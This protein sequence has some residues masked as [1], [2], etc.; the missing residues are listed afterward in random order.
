[1]INPH[2]KRERKAAMLLLISMLIIT[3][4]SRITPLSWQYGETGPEMVVLNPNTGDT[5]FVFNTSTTSVG[6]RFNATVWIYNVTDMFGYQTL[7]S[8]NDTLLNIT[9]A[10]LPTW[11]TNWVFYGQSS[12]QPIPAFRD[13]NGNGVFE[14]VLVGASLLIGTPFNGTGLLSIIE[15]EIIFEPTSGSVSCNLDIDNI[16]SYALDFD[17]T[18]I[19]LIKTGGYYEFIFVPGVPV[20]PTAD[21]TY[22]PL[23][24]LVNE[25]ITFD[26]ST[27]TPNGGSIAN[28]TWNFDDGTPQVAETDPITTHTYLS[29]GT[30]NVTLTVIDTEGLNDT[31]WQTITVSPIVPTIPIIK[32]DPAYYNATHVGDVFNVTIKI[33][34]LTATSKMIGFQFRLGY[35]NTFVEVIDIIEGPFLA[36]FNQTPTPP[37][38]FFMAFD[39]PNDPVWGTHAVIGNVLLPNSTG[40]Y[41]GPFPQGEGVVAIITFEVTGVFPG[42]FNLTLFDT[43]FIDSDLN[44]IPHTTMDGSFE[45]LA[46]TV[47]ITEQPKP[48]Y[49]SLSI[50]SM[51][52]TVR[53]PDGTYFTAGNLGSITVWIYNGTH[54]VTSISLAAE[55]FNPATNEWT[56]EWQI[57]VDASPS[58][59]YSFVIHTA[60]IIDTVGPLV[61]SD[62]SSNTFNIISVEVLDVQ[63]DVG[64]IHFRGEMAEFSVLTLLNGKR[65]GDSTTGVTATLYKPD[66]TTTVLSVSYVAIGFFKVTYNIP[67]IDPTGTY[68]LMVEVGFVTTTV[69]YS[70]AAIKSFLISPTL[71]NW[72]P[73]I[74]YINGTIATIETTIG[75]IQLDLQ[76]INAT[77]I[78]IEG[79]LV[80]IDSTLGAMYA[81]IN[82]TN[83]EIIAINATLATINTAVGA[84]QTSLTSLDAKITAINGTVV[85]INTAVGAIQTSLTSL[86]AKITAIDGTVATI[87]TTL[88]TITAQL[89]ELDATVTAIDGNVATID[90]SLGEVKTTLGDVHSA[91]TTTLYVTSVLSAIA[92]IVG[93]IILLL[94]MRKK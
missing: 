84:I 12:V 29:N 20:P 31:T 76:A 55:D 43:E 70:G 39:E 67:V 68:T 54:Y 75:Q 88:G 4:A 90:T 36:A 51:N 85:T 37:P 27:S 26:A 63:I 21:F 8:V 30:F 24:P 56:V 81:K 9:N 41:P 64:E 62:V 52:F 13:N 57:P 16:D 3:I 44:Y 49:G 91:T 50:S 45:L 69:E 34:N 1:M 23:S 46:T 71:T 87:D 59:N 47:T 73:M 42:T 33:E 40:G 22:S 38:T 15:F 58:S 79:D 17:L 32:V 14:A 2:S 6:T 18:P 66:G 74:T 92:A 19:S 60:E 72:D 28:Y 86:D 77:L 11:D 83:A 5:N 94:L 78:G 7:L 10:W 82:T 61:F 48:L 25:T 89:D 65:F 35:N 80:V 93:I 53:Y